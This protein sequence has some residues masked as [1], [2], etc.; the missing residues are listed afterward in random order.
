MSIKGINGPLENVPKT[1]IAKKCP[2][3]FAQVRWWYNRFNP[4]KI[5]SQRE[6]KVRRWLC[7]VT[8]R[9]NSAVRKI[10]R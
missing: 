2:C 3:C 1:G 6:E 9:S 5:V 8:C 7:P 4:Q 10:K